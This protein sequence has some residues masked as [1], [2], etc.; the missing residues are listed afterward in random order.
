MS[1]KADFIYDEVLKD[2]NIQ[3]DEWMSLM[4]FIVFGKNNFL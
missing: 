4:R 3:M 1:K 2:T